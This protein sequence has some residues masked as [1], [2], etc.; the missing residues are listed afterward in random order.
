M[1]GRKRYLL[2][3]VLVG[4]STWGPLATEVVRLGVG[5]ELEDGSLGILSV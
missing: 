5:C 2:L 3:G 1:P 4:K